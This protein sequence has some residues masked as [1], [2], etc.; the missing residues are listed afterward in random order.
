MY[1]KG[2]TIFDFRE[3]LVL[4]KKKSTVLEVILFY[5]VLFLATERQHPE[6]KYRNLQQSENCKWTAALFLGQD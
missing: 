4:K 6:G 5:R 1:L 3:I 2:F